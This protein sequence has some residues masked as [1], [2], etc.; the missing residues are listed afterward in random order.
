MMG[1]SQRPPTFPVR[2]APSKSFAPIP[3]PALAERSSPSGKGEIPS[4]LLQRA[5]P[6][7]TLRLYRKAG[8]SD[9]RFVVLGECTPAFPVTSAACANFT[10]CRGASPR[11]AKRLPLSTEN[12]EAKARG[13]KN[14]VRERQTGETGA[15]PPPPESK[16]RPAHLQSVDKPAQM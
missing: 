5:S 12:G 3:R 7:A 1:Y 9:L 13:G 2:P 4:Y 15:L 14:Y 16:Y 10:E 8:W 6:L 11:F